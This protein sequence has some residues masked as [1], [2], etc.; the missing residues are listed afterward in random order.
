MRFYVIVVLLVSIPLVWSVLG[1]AAEDNDTSANYPQDSDSD[2][3]SETASHTDSQPVDP[4]TG[5]PLS[6]D[7]DSDGFGP[8][9]GDC[10]DGEPAIGPS[11]LEDLG[12][13]GEGDGID[14]DCD[15]LTD[16]PESDPCDCPGADSSAQSLAEALGLC[17]ARFLVTAQKQMTAPFGDLGFAVSSAM[18]ANNC[19]V[20]QQGCGMAILSTGPV[21]Q[22]NPNDAVSMGSGAAA[23]ALDPQPQYRGSKKI[24][25]LAK[26][27][28][29]DVSQLQLKLVAP[30][31]AQGFAFD[32]L[33][34]SA[35]YDEFINSAY[36]DTFYAILEH[37]DVN[38][39]KTTNIAFDDNDHEIQVNTN[40]F[41]NNAHPCDE[42]GSGWEP[43]IDDKSGSTGWLRTTWP[44]S[45]G[46]EFTLTFS[47]HD[48]GDCIYDSIVLIDDFR[49][50]TAPVE[51]GTV[52]K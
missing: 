2:S 36:N 6:S 12:T 35:E 37:P 30:A 44:V 49:W 52:P 4:D 20:T 19:M 43:E 17:D 31:N 22:S 41:E 9:Q 8:T 26:S 16:E 48:E 10:N 23:L 27:P 7:S 25:V 1:C 50:S 18:G 11:A 38:G 21:G 42:S 32:F 34:A 14:N 45:G 40:Y 29:C 24:S 39:G 3:E 47:I 13:D 51:S 33:F 15:G 5:F 46:D 28:S